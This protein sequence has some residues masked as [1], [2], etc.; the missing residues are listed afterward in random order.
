M[1]ERER[2]RE[3]I[4]TQFSFGKQEVNENIVPKTK[5]KVLHSHQRTIQSH[6]HIKKNINCEYVF[7]YDII[8]RNDSLVKRKKKNIINNNNIKWCSHSIFIWKYWYTYY[9]DLMTN[10]HWFNKVYDILI[11]LQS[12]WKQNEWN[13]KKKLIKARKDE[14]K[15]SVNEPWNRTENEIQTDKY[16]I[17]KI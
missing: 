3:K 15:N 6:D 4:V 8:I 11:T 16:I 13:L 7:N 5:K 1:R 9:Y 12:L 10:F 2:E 14:D 17:K